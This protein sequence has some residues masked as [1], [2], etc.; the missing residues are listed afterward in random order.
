[1]KIFGNEFE[2]EGFGLSFEWDY[3]SRMPPDSM[4]FYRDSGALAKETEPLYRM[5]RYVEKLDAD[6]E[7]LAKE[8]DLNFNLTLLRNGDVGGELI[9]T[10]GHL[11]VKVPGMDDSFPEAYHV[12]RGKLC[13][14]QMHQ[15]GKIFRAI[16]AAEGD[17]VIVPPNYAHVLV[18]VG[19]G[20]LLM[21]DANAG[22]SMRGGHDYGFVKDRQGLC[23]YLMRG[24]EFVKNPNYTEFPPIKRE[25][26]RGILPKKQLDE[27]FMENPAFLE[28]ILKNRI[29]MGEESLFI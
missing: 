27:L 2:V 11:H 23:Y 26:P 7:R 4:G 20:P 14:L 19:Q 21:L 8:W 1:M 22:E 15:N 18:N 28:K 6:A 10:N 9:K 5:Y 17:T 12:M 24:M 29:R 16:S 3:E 25:N 13:F